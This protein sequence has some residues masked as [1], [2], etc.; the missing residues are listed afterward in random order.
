MLYGAE[1]WALTDRMTGILVTCD[2]KMLRYKIGVRWQDGVS[3]SVVAARCELE[4]VLRT[5]RLQ[6]F[7][8]VR[9]AGEDS[10]VREVGE[11]EGRCPR[12]RPRGIAWSYLTVVGSSDCKRR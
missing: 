8:H 5:R 7:G 4:G 11:L 6:W 3:S 1:T 2:C 9:R 10:M 12:G